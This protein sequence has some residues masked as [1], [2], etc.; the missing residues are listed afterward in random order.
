MQHFKLL[1]QL[2]VLK[3][4]LWRSWRSF[5][6]VGWSRFDKTSVFVDSNF[7]KFEGLDLFPSYEKILL[8]KSKSYPD[9]STINESMANFQSE[10]IENIEWRH[11]R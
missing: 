4:A 5:V 2:E 8:A 11:Y 10:N 3:A 9:G 1:S 7:H 6:T